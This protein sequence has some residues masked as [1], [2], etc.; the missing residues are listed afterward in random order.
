MGGV[1]AGVSGAFLKAGGAFGGRGPGI[2]G[3]FLIGDHGCA[4]SQGAYGFLPQF[5]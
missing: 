4:F 5:F 2:C 1:Y 3:V